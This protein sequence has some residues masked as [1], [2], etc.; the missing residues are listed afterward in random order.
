MTDVYDWKAEDAFDDDA[1]A[2]AVYESSRV[3]RDLF[4]NSYN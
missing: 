4:D 3:V 1:V 2:Q